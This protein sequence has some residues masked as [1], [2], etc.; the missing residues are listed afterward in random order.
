MPANLQIKERNLHKL[1]RHHYRQYRMDNYTIIIITAHWDLRI[2]LLT[3]MKA[4]VREQRVVRLLS[5][6]RHLSQGEKRFTVIT[7]SIRLADDLRLTDMSNVK[8]WCTSAN[9]WRFINSS[10]CAT[11][12]STFISSSW[13]FRSLSRNFCVL[14][15]NG[16]TQQ[17]HSIWCIILHCCGFGFNPITVSIDGTET[18]FT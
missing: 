15:Y 17:E 14:L 5:F 6:V 3:H 9:S 18:K 1:F 4:I 11:S 10:I 16:P 7:V 2:S 12:C 8:G 13:I